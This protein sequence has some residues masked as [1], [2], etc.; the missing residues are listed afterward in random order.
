MKNERAISNASP[1]G[2]HSSSPPAMYCHSHGKRK[3]P[4]RLGIVKNCEVLQHVG[5]LS[6]QSDIENAT[7]QKQ[8][9]AIDGFETC[10]AVL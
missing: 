5:G 2:I 9:C 3:Y 7:K 6:F 8:L 4:W 10:K 1:G